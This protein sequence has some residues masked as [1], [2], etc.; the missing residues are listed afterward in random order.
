MFVAFV[1]DQPRKVAVVVVIEHGGGGGK[2]AAPMARK[3]ICRYY[4]LPDPG[5]PK[6]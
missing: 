5:E 2:I 6:D 3:I 1:D 4:G